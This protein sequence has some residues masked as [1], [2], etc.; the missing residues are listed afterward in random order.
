MSQRQLAKYLLLSLIPT[1][2][3]ALVGSAI[4]GTTGSLPA[5][6]QTLWALSILYWPIALIAGLVLHYV[7]KWRDRK[8]FRATQEYAQMNGW[9]PISSTHWRN[10]KRN[11]I[12]LAVAKSLTDETF[13]LTVEVEGERV[14]VDQFENSLWA[15]QFGD[16]LWEQ[17]PL[18][19]QID[20]GV[21]IE[22]RAEWEQSQALVR[23][24]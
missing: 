21:V 15:L 18:A 4:I 13:I 24:S 16:W 8:L 23:V 17:L 7:V 20:P 5:L 1:G 3:Y 9:L 11:Q 2:I 14:T 19:G 6:L 12:Q 22:K 10:R